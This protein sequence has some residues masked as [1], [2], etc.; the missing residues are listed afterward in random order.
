M[1]RMNFSYHFCDR[2]KVT[3]EHWDFGEGGLKFILVAHWVIADG[4][5][6]TW[7]KVT[8]QVSE[9][10]SDLVDDGAE[11]TRRSKTGSPA[12]GGMR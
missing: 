11:G 7:P 9:L 2:A 12:S 6:P 4:G 8:L 10:L 5:C 1:A 3:L